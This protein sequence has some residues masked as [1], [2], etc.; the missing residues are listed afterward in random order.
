[1]IKFILRQMQSISNKN[2]DD[3]NFRFFFE[4][5]DPI[6]GQNPTFSPNNQLFSTVFTFQEVQIYIEKHFRT[7]KAPKTD[8]NRPIL[9]LKMQKSD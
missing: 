7:L 5:F 3:Q 1:M 8:P 4:I 6:S 9:D 2:L